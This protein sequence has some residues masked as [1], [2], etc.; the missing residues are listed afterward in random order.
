VFGIIAQG[1]HLGRPS[2]I[3]VTLH[4]DTPTVAGRAVISATGT[5]R[6]P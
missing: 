4:D 1:H 3:E 6:L 5:L 2:R